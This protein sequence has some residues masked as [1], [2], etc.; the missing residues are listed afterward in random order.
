MKNQSVAGCA[1][2]A[3]RSHAFLALCVHART[4]IVSTEA[5]PRDCELTYP[6][7]HQSRRAS[8]ER[9]T[10]QSGT[11]PGAR[12]LHL[13]CSDPDYQYEQ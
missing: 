12:Q 7:G 13:K 9:Q 10:R 2:F 8:G 4:D 5:G 6:P 11:S 3:R 1:V